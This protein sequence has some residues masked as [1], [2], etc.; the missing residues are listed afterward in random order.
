MPRNSG[1]GKHM[2]YSPSIGFNL[3]WEIRLATPDHRGS[4]DVLS[5]R[6]N[7]TTVSLRFPHLDALDAWI[8]QL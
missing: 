5:G 2:K 1:P 6:Q 3:C 7:G 8:T 4:V